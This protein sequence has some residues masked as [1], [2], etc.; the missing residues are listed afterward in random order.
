MWSQFRATGNTNPPFD[1][2]L[3]MAFVDD[4]EVVATKP[5]NIAS[6][7]NYDLETDDTIVEFGDVNALSRAGLERIVPLIC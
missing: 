1:W 6:T 7:S 4:E 5:L 3:F 2:S